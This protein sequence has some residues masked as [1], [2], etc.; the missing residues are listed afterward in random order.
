MNSLAHPES[1][2]KLLS[3]V[4]LVRWLQIAPELNLE[5]ERVSVAAGRLS[6]IRGIRIGKMRNEGIS[7]LVKRHVNCTESTETA[8]DR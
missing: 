5:S 8:L 2:K 1:V 6:F 3:A 4:R 7:R